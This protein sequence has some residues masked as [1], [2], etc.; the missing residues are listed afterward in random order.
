VLVP[1]PS[2]TIGVLDGV[3]TEML[4]LSVVPIGIVDR[5]HAGTF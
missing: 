5:R 3:R 4:F 1:V 2:Y